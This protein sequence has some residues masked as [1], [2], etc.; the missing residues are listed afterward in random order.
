MK[1]HQ[2]DL[3]RAHHDI[4]KDHGREWHEGHHAPE[5]TGSPLRGGVEDEAPGREE[6]GGG[7]DGAEEQIQ[8][9]EARQ[10]ERVDQGERRDRQNVARHP[11]P[12][13]RTAAA[14]SLR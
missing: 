7:E 14:S 6:Q 4:P 9:L 10:R 12:R 3:P 8:G 2:G 11:G 5:K 13:V 1:R